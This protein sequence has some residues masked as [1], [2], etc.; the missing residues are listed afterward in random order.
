MIFN[1]HNRNDIEKYYLHTYLKFKETGDRIFKLIGVGP[2]SV[3]CVDSAGFDIHIDLAA[4][5]EVNYV[6]PGRRVFQINEYAYMLYRRPARQYYR[7]MHHENTGF[8]MLQSN[9]TW[10]E[11]LFDFSLIE[12][13][14]NKNNYSSVEEIA[15]GNKESYALNHQMAVSKTGGVLFGNSLIATINFNKHEGFVI[16]IYNADMENMFRNLKIEWK[17][18]K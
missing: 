3:R 16:P 11:V 7:G 6:L 14:V 18:H 2:N 10:K 12:S 9:G 1:Q 8:V 4:E 13:Y 5:Y 17:N 15:T